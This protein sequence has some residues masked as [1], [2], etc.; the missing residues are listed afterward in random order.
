MP[1]QIEFPEN[2][3][4]YRNPLIA[5]EKI[6]SILKTLEVEGLQI[7]WKRN[8]HSLLGWIET[9]PSISEDQDNSDT[10]NLNALTILAF[11][12]CWN[13][14]NQLLMAGKYSKALNRYAETYDLGQRFVVQRLGVDESVTDKGAAALQLPDIA[15]ANEDRKNRETLEELYCRDWEYPLSWSEK[16]RPN[17]YEDGMTLA[18]RFSD[19]DEHQQ[20]WQWKV[21]FPIVVITYLLTPIAAAEAALAAG[22]TGGEIPEPEDTLPRHAVACIE[23]VLARREWLNQ[24]IELPYVRMLAAEIWMQRGDSSYRA[25]NVEEAREC[26]ENAQQQ[27]EFAPESTAFTAQIT[28]ATQ[29]LHS[30]INAFAT[31]NVV[32]NPLVPQLWRHLKRSMNQQS[33]ARISLPPVYTL[34]DVSQRNAMS[35]LVQK[36]LLR[37][38]DPSSIGSGASQTTQNPRWGELV[39]LVEARKRKVDN[40]MNYFGYRADYVPPWRF[41][42]LLER[43]R[44]F[45]NR[46]REIQSS[47]LQ[48]I[49]TAEK[50][51][52]AESQARQTLVLEEQGVS[53]AMQRVTQANAEYQAA[54]TANNQ[55][56]IAHTNAQLR[57]M[58]YQV[59]D[60]AMSSL[61]AVAV[62]SARREAGVNAAE[63]MVH[64]ALSGMSSVLGSLIGAVIAGATS[65]PKAVAQSKQIRMQSDMQ[66]QQR[67]LEQQNL[68][69]ASRETAAAS[70]TAAT[71][72]RASLE[73]FEVTKL[74]QAAAEMRRDF[75]QQTQTFLASRT[76]SA[77]L[78][79]RLAQ[80]MQRLA[81]QYLDYANELAF[82]TE[83]AFEFE[84]GNR[85][86]MIRFDYHLSSVGDFLAGESLLHDLDTIE[87]QYLRNAQERQQQLR[88][89]VSL[90]RDFPDVLE[91]LQ[92]HGTAYLSIPLRA[93]EQRFPGLWNC[94]ISSVGIQPIALM[95]PTRFALQMSHIG[96]GVL[97]VQNHPDTS[98]ALATSDFSSWHQLAD[99]LFP[100]KVQIAKSE[101]EI[102][103]GMSHQEALTESP[104]QANQQRAGFEGLA[105]ATTWYIDMA[106]R[107]NHI[108]PSTLADVIVTFNLTG[109]HDDQLKDLIQSALPT[110]YVQ[111]LSL[112]G[113]TFY[114]DAYYDFQKQGRMQ[115]PITSDI[116]PTGMRA[117]R[118]QNVALTLQPTPATAHFGRIISSLSIDL[119][120]ARGSRY[121][122]VKTPIPQVRWFQVKGLTVSG[123][124]R[125]FSGPPGVKNTTYAPVTQIEICAGEDNHFESVDVTE[126]Y[127]HTY[128]QPGVYTITLRAVSN[129]RR[130]TYTYAV[131]VSE[132]QNLKEPLTSTFGVF[133]KEREEHAAICGLSRSEDDSSGIQW[134][135]SVG[136]Q[137][138]R[139]RNSV[140]E[141][142]FADGEPYRLHCVT[143]RNLNARI[144]TEQCY[145]PANGIV[146]AGLGT[147]TNRQ[148]ADDGNIVNGTDDIPP[149]NHL[150]KHFFGDQGQHE[151][152]PLDQWTLELPLDINP[153][154]ESVTTSDAV[155][156]DLSEI[157]DVILSLEYEALTQ[158]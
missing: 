50:E 41:A 16:Q 88:Y 11:H 87:H 99:A 40:G 86:D 69:L 26:Y 157:Q 66:N 56:Q 103:S 98:D 29:H 48:F 91:Q 144:L 19:N 76:T 124:F 155:V 78:W 10:I 20:A 130:Y 129:N 125:F 146:I 51:D 14:A 107:E 133:L 114:P 65:I 85:M 135:W 97:R 77:E 137:S 53:I 42:Y 44:Y 127:A 58:H 27:L 132:S 143:M 17:A 63:S 45:I 61:Q 80:R 4:T 149:L 79:Y 32:F 123:Q 119:E 81:R 120:I 131:A 62:K 39:L 96:A 104:Q 83:Q 121:L 8:Y 140:A 23:S 147:T 46:L 70:E 136:E 47:Y 139:T 151:L 122:T 153:C 116:V 31:E 108:E 24:P 145:Q 150:A 59:F 34:A 75:A 95:D 67:A 30:A 1:N 74:E 84:S 25:G 60:V 128:R 2:Y 92:E 64:G 89:V 156:P 54:I 141:C 15:D 105:A 7:L 68:A 13:D 117:G 35:D 142:T 72:E 112:S 94:R 111:T 52:L 6:I 118:L 73:A 18:G 100:A 115:I 113:R 3:Y 154:L 109:Y 57:A 38:D 93:I 106:L 5:I 110:S 36:P 49:T 138:G 90:A 101:T 55:A 43:A 71:Q 126:S 22:F 21:A 102:F 33:V 134:Y 158:Q 37:L 28:R 152:S 82:L 12:A 148:I 9:N